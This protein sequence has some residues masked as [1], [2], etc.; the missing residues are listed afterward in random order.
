MFISSLAYRKV[1]PKITL[2]IFM[3]IFVL[4]LLGSVYAHR[5]FSYIQHDE[6]YAIRDLSLTN[7]SS[8]VFSALFSQASD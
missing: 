6:D 4:G 7:L 2:P 1:R 5:C 8:S 3:Q